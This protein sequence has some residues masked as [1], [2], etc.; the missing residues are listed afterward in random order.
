MKF[1]VSPP[2]QRAIV[3]FADGPAKG[4]WWM[5]LLKPGYRHCGALIEDM[6]TDV[7]SGHEI[8]VGINPRMGG[9]EVDVWATHNIDELLAQLKDPRWDVSRMIITRV[10]PPDPKRPYAWF[11]CTCVEQIKRALGVRGW[12]I[13]TPW[14]LYRRI[15]NVA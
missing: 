15:A 11:P 3:W 9:T 6:H 8:W 7:A 1:D 14:Q 13:W 12:W 2:R 4:P 5:H 10:D